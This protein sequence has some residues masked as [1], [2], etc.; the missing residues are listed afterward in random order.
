MGYN[1]VYKIKCINM[2]ESYVSKISTYKKV[3]FLVLILLFSVKS[4]AQ[5]CSVIS[6]FTP[7]CIGTTQ[8]YTAE[9][10]G[11][12]ARDITPGNNYGCL[13][14]TP[15]SKWFFFQASTGG[16]LIINQTNSNNVDVDGA[17]WGP[18]DSINDMLSQCGSFSTPLDCD[19]EPES[20]FTF[21]I[22]TVTSGKYYAFLVT[23]FSGDPTNITLSDGGSTATTNCSQDSDG[24]NIADVYDLDDDNDGILDI[25]EQSC[26]TTNVP[27]ANASSATSSTGVSSPGNAIGSDNQLAWMNSSSEELIVNLGSVIP[28]GVTIT[29]EAMK[30][31]N[32]GGNNVQMIVEESY[33]GVSFTSSTTYTFNNNNAE[34]LKSYTINS[35]AQYL[36]IHGV[37]FGGGRW[38][39]VDNVSYSSFSYTNC[40]DINTDGDAFV[41]RLDVDSDNDGCPD[42]VEGDEN[43]EVYQLDGNDR[44]NIFSTG[45]ITNFG[46]P[47][48]VNSGG[49]ADI[50]GDEGQGVGSKLVFSADASPNLIITP[51]PTVCFSN[52]VDLTAN[53]VTDGTN[54]S[55]TAGTL[56][57]WTDAAATNT[58]ATPNAIAANGTYYIKL[59]SASGCYEIEPVVV[60][61]QDE[62]TAG[63][64]AGDQVI[65]SGGDPITF[66]SDTDGSGSGT[67]SYRWESSED[68]VN[69]SSISGE[70]SSTYD[71]NVLTITTQFRRVT[72]STENSVACES[73]PTS[74]VTVIVDTNDVD[75]DGINDI[76]DLDDDNDGILDS[77]EGNCTTNYFAVFGGNGGSTTNFSQSA[78]SSVVFDFYYVDNSVAIEINGGGLNA[79]N[80]LQLENAA[81]AGE[82]FLEFTDGAA[83]SIPWVANNNGLPRLKVE[84]DFSGNVTVYGSRSTNSTSLELMQIRGGGT[85]NTISF[86]A[87]TNNFNVINQD[88]PGLDGIGGVVK[89]YSSCVDTDNDNIPDYLDTD[90]DGDGCFDAIE[91]D[92]NVSISDLSGGRITGGVDSD[93]VPN[94]VNSG[95][96]ADGGNNTQGQGVGTS[97][98]ANADAVP[99]LIIT[100]PASVCSP[101][102]VDL[103]ASTVT[104]GANGS[105]SAGTLTYWTD[106]AA[107]NTLVSPNAVATSGTYYIKLTSA[108]GCYEI[109]P[110]KVTIKTTPSAPVV[111]V[112]DNCDGTSTLST[113]ASGTLLWSTGESTASITVNSAGDYS[114]TTTVDGCTSAAGTGTA[115]PKTT[116]SAPVVTV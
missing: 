39:G 92:E 104:D 28:A 53:N 66:T 101:S 48:L 108:S 42:A 97:A 114:V 1:I 7:V 95:E 21:N 33:D 14:F 41:D 29:I 40:A 87:G 72:I 19:Y 36:R 76:C 50:G 4:F 47:N 75:S 20:F 51:P 11:G 67:I 52:T 91:G 25:D 100:N 113:T 31:R 110:V 17:I 90:S 3:F 94:I 44:I 12:S 37:N 109:E 54:G 116:P 111:T 23:N 81:G 38:L 45:G 58:L 79:N 77:L 112:V 46:V 60:T 6:D 62:V 61:I 56:T 103:M 73:S 65:C 82:V 69:W 78:V 15:N 80:I 49:A 9:T 83:M 84:V 99:T 96:P 63:T 88:I 10:S 55:S 2:G 30:Y 102:T 22:P 71:P 26:T 13:N 74:V 68:G 106:S 115:A 98:T 16:S 24:D 85:F 105:S 89:V 34:E 8:T 93:G 70:T 57:Y 107:T 64:I 18:F 32:S 59:T 35:D 5:D 43:V 27:G 86:L